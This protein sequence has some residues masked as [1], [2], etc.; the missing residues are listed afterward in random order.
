MIGDLPRRLQVALDGGVLHGLHVAE[1]GE[2][3]PPTE[4]LDAS[5]PTFTSTP[6]RSRIA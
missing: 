6:V 3:S 2:A 1:V 4:S 5:T